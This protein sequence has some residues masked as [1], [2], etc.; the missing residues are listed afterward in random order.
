MPGRKP[1]GEIYFQNG[2]PFFPIQQAS[3]LRNAISDVV[4][5]QPKAQR[6]RMTGRPLANGAWEAGNS[7]NQAAILQ[8][9]MEAVYKVEITA[10]TSC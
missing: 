2:K 8:E 3:S 5:H 4:N 6:R 7:S 9:I 10:E 1:N